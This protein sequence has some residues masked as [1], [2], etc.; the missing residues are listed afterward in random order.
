MNYTEYLEYLKDTKDPLYYKEGKLPQCPPG[1]I[2]NSKKKDCVP[3]TE[4]D[5]LDGKLNDKDR[6]N[7]G[8]QYQVWGKTGVNGDG[9]A[10]ED[11]P[12]TD[13]NASHWDTH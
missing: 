4:K 12:G 10:Y 11:A 2:W 8:A 3:K 5:K 13:I 1:Y 9:Y 7:S 6:S